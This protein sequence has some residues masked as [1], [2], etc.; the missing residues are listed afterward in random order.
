MIAHD[1][2]VPGFPQLAANSAEMKGKLV[3]CDGSSSLVPPKTAAGQDYLTVEQLLRA[4][5]VTREGAASGSKATSCGMSLD[6]A[7]LSHGST[8]TAR[9]DGLELL[10][11][12]SLSNTA[13]W[14]GQVDT[15]YE[16]SVEAVFGSKSKVSQTIWTGNSTDTRTIRDAHGLRFNVVFTGEV[17]AYDT[18]TLLLQ[19]TSSLALLAL[20]TTITDQVAITFMRNKGLYRDVKYEGVE[21]P[22]DDLGTLHKGSAAG[23]KSD[24]KG[25]FYEDASRSISKAGLGSRL[26]AAD[27]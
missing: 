17:G 27:A 5:K 3:G 24:L 15:T 16:Y 13:P 10:L 18:T 14:V 26:L 21:V 1:V 7:S 4:A 19:L 9:Y 25:A 6:D 8:K 22:G 12:I 11:S 20:A 2:V 23:D